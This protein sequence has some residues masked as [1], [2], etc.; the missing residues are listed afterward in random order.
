MVP[1]PRYVLYFSYRAVAGQR[2]QSPVQWKEFLFPVAGWLSRP[3]WLALGPGLLA[4]GPGWLAIGPGWLS[5]GPGWLAGPL[6]CKKS[7][8]DLEIFGN[9]DV[10]TD[11]LRGYCGSFTAV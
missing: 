5:I 11:T 8:V 9:S 7:L 10:Q 2:P 4:L 1:L 6:Y 3:G